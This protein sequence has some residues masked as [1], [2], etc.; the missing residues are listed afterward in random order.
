MRQALQTPRKD[1]SRHKGRRCKGPEAERA[2]GKQGDRAAEVSSKGRTEAKQVGEREG[3]GDR[4]S[5]VME[6]GG[7]CMESMVDGGR[8]STHVEEED[9]KGTHIHCWADEWVLVE[10]V[11]LGE[12]QAIWKGLLAG[13]REHIGFEFTCTNIFSVSP[14]LTDGKNTMELSGTE[15]HIK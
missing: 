13:S 14:P 15:S 8:K 5:Q 1:L 10:C 3:Q 4:Q 11:S 2:S 7:P 9:G 6:V 12:K